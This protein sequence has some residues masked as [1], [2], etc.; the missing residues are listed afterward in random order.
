M[1]QFSRRLALA[2]G[3]ALP[4]L[5]TIRRFPQLAPALYHGLLT[6]LSLRHCRAIRAKPTWEYAHAEME[7]RFCTHPAPV[8]ADL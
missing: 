3:I 2:F 4:V 5:E 7:L 1:F 6:R 8:A